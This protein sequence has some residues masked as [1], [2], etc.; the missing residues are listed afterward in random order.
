[1]SSTGMV[2][3]AGR[4]HF[5]EEEVRQACFLLPPPR[6]GRLLRS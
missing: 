1:M 2:P 6:G 5:S 3:P 4:K